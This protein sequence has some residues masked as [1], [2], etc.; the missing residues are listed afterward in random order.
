MEN[1]HRHYL[2]K[3]S[4]L[5]NW[6]KRDLYVNQKLFI[7]SIKEDLSEELPTITSG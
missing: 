6:K 2:M 3:L 1:V 5:K 4:D 7:S